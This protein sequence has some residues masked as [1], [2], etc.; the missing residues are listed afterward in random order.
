MVKYLDGMNEVPQAQLK[1]MLKKL[2]TTAFPTEL[3][4]FNN[5]HGIQR[6]SQDTSLERAKKISSTQ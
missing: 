3:M 5:Q 4:Q 2:A 6:R 1:E